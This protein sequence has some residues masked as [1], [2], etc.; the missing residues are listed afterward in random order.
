MVI[1]DLNAGVPL[2]SYIAALPL[3]PLTFTSAPSA[4]FKND[5]TFA[6]VISVTTPSEPAL[7]PSILASVTFCNLEYVIPSSFTLN[8]SEF[9]SIVESSTLTAKLLFADMSPPPVRPSPAL[10]VT[11]VWSTCSFA[12][13]LFNESWSISAGTATAVIVVPLFVTSTPLEPNIEKSAE[14][15]VSSALLPAPVSVV[16]LTPVMS[17]SPVPAPIYERR[18]APVT[19]LTTPES[20]IKNLSVSLPISSILLINKVPDV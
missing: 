5:N 12:T 14:P 8:E 15:P 11:D 17:P 6:F 4:T 9:I 20:D 13:K 3:S 16:I 7:L 18:L 19:N 2:L 10:N 1:P